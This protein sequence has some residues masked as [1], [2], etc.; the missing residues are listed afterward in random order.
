MYKT[1]AAKKSL[2]GLDLD[3]A[4]VQT[5]AQLDPNELMRLAEV[6]RSLQGNTTPSAPAQT[7]TPAVSRGGA[8]G[9]DGRYYGVVK[10]FNLGKGFGFISCDQLH[11]VYGQDVFLHKNEYAAADLYE[12]ANVSFG[13]Q[14]NKQQQPQATGVTLCEYGAAGAKRRRNDEGVQEYVAAAKKQRVAPGGYRSDDFVETYEVGAGAK[15]YQTPCVEK[16][17]P[18]NVEGGPFVGSVKSYNESKGFGFITC[19]ET[20]SKYNR[21]IFLHKNEADAIPGLKIGDSVQFTLQLNAQGNPQAVG[22]TLA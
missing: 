9:A 22:T 21:D 12:G 20:F 18:V 14:I 2:G 7:Y 3:P 16:S 17:P 11:N 4:T 5:L 10:S 8:S 15:K 13:I 19:D 1:A 6:A